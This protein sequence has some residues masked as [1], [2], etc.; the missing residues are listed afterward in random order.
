MKKDWTLV[1]TVDQEYKAGLAKE[2]LEEEGI[3]A[4][5]M[6][7][8]DSA[9]QTFGEFEVYVNNKFAEQARKKLQDSKI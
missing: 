1:Y 4:V 6:N 7:K 2:L 9:Y 8:H 5:I 3:T